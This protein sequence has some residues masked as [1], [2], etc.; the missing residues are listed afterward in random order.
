MSPVFQVPFNSKNK[1]M[2]TIHDLPGNQGSKNH[3]SA[4]ML[5]YMKGAAESMIGR[6]N[7]VL[8]EDGEV[9]PMTPKA[10]KRLLATQVEMCQKGE[11]VLG[12]I[13]KTVKHSKEC[14]IRDKEFNTDD[15]TL[16]IEDGFTFIGLIAL[17]DPPRVEVPGVI[18]KCHQ[19]GIKVAMVTGDHPDTAVT[20]ARMIGIVKGA[21]IAKMADFVADGLPAPDPESTH[22]EMTRTTVEFFRDD[23]EAR[24]QPRAVVVTGPELLTFYDLKWDW[25]LSHRDIVFA[26]TSPENKL[27]IVKQM[28]ARGY[29][30][31]VTGDGVNDSPALKQA[32]VGVA[33]GGGSEVAKEAGAIILTDNN[34]KSLLHGV[35]SGRLVFANL[36]KVFRYLMPAGTFAE[37]LPVLA[38]VFLGLPQPLSTFLMIYI[39]VITDVA[40]CMSLVFEKSESDVMNQPP[41]SKKE[42][43]LDGMIYLQ[44]YAFSGVIEALCAFTMF[45]YYMSHYAHIPMSKLWLA[46]EKYNLTPTAITTYPN[47]KGGFYT[48]KEL[49]NFLN[50]GQTVYFAALIIVQFGNLIGSKSQ[51]IAIWKAN[52]LIGSTRN[53]FLLFS[54]PISLGFALLVVYIPGLNNVFLTAPIPWEFWFLPL[55]FSF[56]LFILQELRKFLWRNLPWSAISRALPCF[57]SASCLR[58]S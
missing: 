25:V 2:I 21:S 3:K 40:P 4:K 22:S 30:V 43:L 52:P 42:H 24:A 37:V 50:T 12:M 11:R 49:A 1:Y 47:P 19:A 13:R 38:N 55:Y 23:E 15:Y 7:S 57:K 20:I 26:R 10:R 35:E 6:C 36:K 51:R 48:G 58:A 9:E 34:F 56:A 28:Q 39:C 5:M 29:S 53:L 46:F 31:A 17:M 8:T 32:D 33:M 54:I 41:R 45:F 18:E 16:P 27:E 14:P 44:A